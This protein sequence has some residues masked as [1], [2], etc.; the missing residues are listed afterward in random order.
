MFNPQRR[1]KVN[2]IFMQEKLY[3]LHLSKMKEI[4]H[5]SS[6]KSKRELE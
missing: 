6:P 3:Q 2:D 4:V 5:A 1:A